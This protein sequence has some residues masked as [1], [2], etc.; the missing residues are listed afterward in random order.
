MGDIRQTPLNE[1]NTTQPLL[2]LA[3]P[4]LFPMGQV[5]FILPR[6][7]KVNYHDYVKHA[8]KWHDGRFASHPRFRF[9]AFNT[10][11]R[12]TVNSKS[13]YFVHHTRQAPITAEELRN[14]FEA[15]TDDA[16]R[17]LNSIVR[18]SDGVK[19]TRPFWNGKR[20]ELESHVYA[21]DCPS[22]FMTFSP[23]DLHWDSL[24]RHMP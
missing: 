3:F 18:F 8:M 17:L 21:L 2:S 16:R 5:E 4:T 12:Q 9:V 15:Q 6:Y 22:L 1:F 24:A 23:A 19:G 10:M 14:A 20:H 11:M 7:H 13:T